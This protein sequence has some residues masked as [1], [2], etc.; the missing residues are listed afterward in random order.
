MFID[1]KIIEHPPH[2]GGGGI[3]AFR[4]KM[5]VAWGLQYNIGYEPTVMLLYT[6]I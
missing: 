5:A 4:I 2:Q 3:K 6:F 1:I